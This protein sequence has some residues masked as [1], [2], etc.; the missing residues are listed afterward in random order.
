MLWLAGSR[1]RFRWIGP[2]R[3]ATKMSDVRLWLCI[4]AV[5]LAGFGLAERGLHAHGE[6]Q[7]HH[8]HAH[9]HGD[10]THTH[11]HSHDADDGHVPQPTDAGAPQPCGGDEHHCCMDHGQPDAVHFT[12]PPRETRRLSDLDTVATDVDVAA[13][14]AFVPEAWAPPRAPP[15]GPSSQDPLP[16]LRTIVLLT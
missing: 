13:G 12:L 2:R 5:G 1:G 15:D 8:T 4:S 6:E 9:R 11:H 14:V 16:Q 7:H 10:T 3:I